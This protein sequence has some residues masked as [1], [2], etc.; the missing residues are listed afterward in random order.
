MIDFARTPENSPEPVTVVVAEDEILIRLVL[1][2]ALRE[3]GFRVLEAGNADDVVAIL[4]AIQIDV[5]VTDLHMARVDDGLVI[6][7]YIREHHPDTPVLLASVMAPPIDGSPF[8]AFFIKP[9]KPED[10]VAWVK[11][12]AP[13]AAL[14]P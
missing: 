7:R 3:A 13:R 9:Y 6:G 5:V 14:S 2:D 11:R 1:A 4:N 8:D 12:R 10:I